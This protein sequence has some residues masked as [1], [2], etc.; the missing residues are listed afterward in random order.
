MPSEPS[1]S[2]STIRRGGLPEVVHLGDGLLAAV[3]ALAE[4]DSAAEPVEF[5]GNGALV[6]VHADPG[7]PG[8]DAQRVDGE[9]S[10]HPHLGRRDRSGQAFERAEVDHGLGPG[11]F[12]PRVLGG[13]AGVGDTADR[14]GAPGVLPADDGVPA[15][16]P[17]GEIGVERADDRML[18]AHVRDLD[19]QHEPHPAE[20]RGECGGLRALEDQPGGAAVVDDADVVLDPA[21][22]IEQQGFSGLPGGESGDALTRER[23][24]PGESVGSGDGHDTTGDLGERRAGREEPLLAERVAVVRDHTRVDAL[25]SNGGGQAEERTGGRADVGVVSGVESVR[26]SLGRGVSRHGRAVQMSGCA[27][28]GRGP[29]CPRPRA[30]RP[31]RGRTGAWPPNSPSHPACASRRRLPGRFG[32]P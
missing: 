12:A 17:G 5:V 30:D 18:I 29:R 8:G 20:E 9:R 21:L 28:P 11:P 4:M 1:R 27:G 24:E 10:G 19:T 31:R 2:S 16:D 32:H 6:G 13:G 14:A 22:R 26:P 15:E 3:A 25:R 23:V 7:T